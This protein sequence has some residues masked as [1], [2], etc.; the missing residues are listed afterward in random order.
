MRGKFYQWSFY[1]NRTTMTFPVW[2]QSAGVFHMKVASP[3][4]EHVQMHAAAAAKTFTLIQSVLTRWFQTKMRGKILHSIID[5]TTD[6]IIYITNMMI[7]FRTLIHFWF[8]Y[9]KIFIYSHFISKYDIF[10]EVWRA[11]GL[12]AL[13][14]RNR[15]LN[16]RRHF[17]IYII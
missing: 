2:D 4:G 16:K 13:H 1:L 12:S 8:E 14:T 6:I 5:Y 15:L 10:V 9:K 17:K 3:S 7:I 11:D